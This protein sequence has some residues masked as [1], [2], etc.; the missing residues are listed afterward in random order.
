[1]KR[2]EYIH[3]AAPI[4]T[5]KQ[6]RVAAKNRGITADEMALHILLE[7][8]NRIGGGAGRV[9]DEVPQRLFKVVEKEANERIRA[10][11]AESKRLR[12]TISKLRG[13]LPAIDE[14]L[15]GA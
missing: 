14:F 13:I 3:F 2:H 6:L 9:E 12:K 10:A 11:E 5:N 1:M 8:L 15:S 4:G 7:G